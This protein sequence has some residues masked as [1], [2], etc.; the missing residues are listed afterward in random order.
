MTEQIERVEIEFL[1]L[2]REPRQ[3]KLILVVCPLDE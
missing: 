2:P 1:V 3:G